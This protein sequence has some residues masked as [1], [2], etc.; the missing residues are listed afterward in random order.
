MRP[1]SPLSLLPALLFLA[2]ST[3]QANNDDR[4]MSGPEAF[5]EAIAM[6]NDAQSSSP[7]EQQPDDGQGAG[8]MRTH[9]IQSP[10]FGMAMSQM[11]LPADW[12]LT[13]DPRNGN[14]SVK[15]PGVKVENS[16]TLMFSHS[17]DPSAN[18]MAQYSGQKVRPF[19]PAEHVV[20][21]DLIPWM[22]Q[23][24][25]TFVGQ[26]DAP[27][28]ASADQRGM[29][30]LYSVAPTRR[31]CYANA[32]EWNKSD[33]TKVFVVMHQCSFEGQGSINWGYQLTI[34]DCTK[35]NFGTA[36]AGLMHG[37]AS[38]RYNPQYF[39]A[40]NAN[41]QRQMQQSW[42]QHN[43]RMQNNQAAFDASQRAYRENA[44]ATNEAIMG[45]YRNQRDASDRG[46][47]QFIN[48]VRD[49]QN[50]VDPNTGQPIKIESGYNQYW[51][52]QNGQYYGTDDVLTDPNVG[53]TTNDVWQQ[54]PTE[55]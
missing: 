50:A 7:N 48:Y 25:C 1:S 41:E 20:Q 36:K 45:T 8:G 19:V 11:E 52:N 16:G 44:N 6:N 24:G 29:D 14:W 15:G 35:A 4:S 33:G 18:Q 40:Y 30:P 10:Q 28:V 23:Q 2:C 51:M 39:A 37:L 38:V 32:S 34:L 26:Q 49:E 12:Q 47:D 42:S 55:E 27:A 5:S 46:Q 31:T 54:V 9:T 3:G 53:N 22:T 21:Q 13:Q 17:Q 43:A